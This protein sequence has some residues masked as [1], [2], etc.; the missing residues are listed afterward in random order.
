MNS[1]L[2]RISEYKRHEVEQAKQERPLDSFNLKQALPVRDFLAGLKKRTPAI[3]AEIKKASPSKGLIRANFDVA[4]IARIYEQHG[5]SCLSVLTDVHFFQGAPSYLAVAKSNSKLPVLRKDFIID[6]YQIHE[7]RALGADCILLIV[8][9]LDDQQLQDYCQLAQ[10]L[11]MAVLVE[12]HTPEEF[13]RALPLPTPLMGVNNRSLHTFVTKIETSL[14]LAEQLPAD[15][16]LISESG[17]N[18]RTD[19]ELMQEH[20][21]NT[22]LIGESLMRVEDIGSKLDEF[23][24]L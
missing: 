20:E 1:I 9:L 6:S 19:I 4:T 5:A 18:S 23:M 15:K 22:F 10:E 3:I 17:I 11:H 7:S 13:H 16:I 21:I 2:N 24:G 14:E 12:S 8:A